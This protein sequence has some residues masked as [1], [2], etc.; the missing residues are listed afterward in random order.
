MSTFT[1]TLASL[2]LLLHFFCCFTSSPASLQLLLHYFSTFTILLLHYSPASLLLLL[3]LL[4]YKRALNGASA[5]SRGH[6]RIQARLAGARPKLSP[7]SQL[8]DSFWRA[9]QAR[10]KHLEL[11]VLEPL[12]ADGEQPVSVEIEARIVQLEQKL[13]DKQVKRLRDRVL[14]DEGREVFQVHPPV[15]HQLCGLELDLRSER[16]Q[17]ECHEE[18]VRSPERRHEHLPKEKEVRHS[19][20]QSCFFPHLTDD[21]FFN[22]LACSA[23]P[24]G[25]V[26]GPFSGR[27]ALLHKQQLVF[28]VDDNAPAPACM[29]RIVGQRAVRRR[30]PFGQHYVVPAGV[31]NLKLVL[32]N[33]CISQNQLACFQLQPE[34]GHASRHIMADGLLQASL[35]LTELQT[36]RNIHEMSN[37]VNVKLN[38]EHL[39]AGTAA[40]GLP[41][42]SAEQCAPL[43]LRKKSQHLGNILRLTESISKVCR[44]SLAAAIK[45]N[46]ALNNKIIAEYCSCSILN[47]AQGLPDGRTSCSGNFSTPNE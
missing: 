6:V 17:Y 23:H 42:L 25:Y 38:F 26:P 9:Y 29:R 47:R 21:T 36:D 13:Q 3:L 44:S 35:K 5:R 7:A 40:E 15:V 45:H 4:L 20:V 2:Q 19:R 12:L 8:D 32:S 1:S 10:V 27:A 11:V 34:P 18:I 16:L 14:L 28:G 33:G 24:L 30:H 22:C 41:A 31:V 43:H 37:V 39:A 46:Q